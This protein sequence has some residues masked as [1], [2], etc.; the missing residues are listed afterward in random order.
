M[1]D[2]LGKIF[3]QSLRCRAG[4]RCSAY[5]NTLPLLAYPSPRSWLKSFPQTAMI[6]MLLILL[7][8]CSF[9]VSAVALPW[10]YDLA[11][12]QSYKAREMARAPAKGTVPVGREIVP[13][14]NQDLDGRKNPQSFT[15]DSVWRG[16]VLYDNNCVPCHGAGGAGNGVSAQWMAVPNFLES[17]YKGR[18]DGWIFGVIHNGQGTMPKYGYKLSID[19]HWDVV[20]YVRFLQGRNMDGLTRPEPG[21]PVKKAE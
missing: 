17:P 15:F 13:E 16:Q 1:S 19:Q 21:E 7:V 4:L 5:F 6:S 12:Q 3:C 18:S 2:S 8:A 10:D 11:R 14:N 9:P 20:N